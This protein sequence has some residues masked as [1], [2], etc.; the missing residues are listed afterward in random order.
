MGEGKLRWSKVSYFG[1]VALFLPGGAIG[2][3]RRVWHLG[4]N[5]MFKEGRPA[6]RLSTLK[7]D[8]IE[9]QDAVDAF[10]PYLDGECCRVGFSHTT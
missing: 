2:P 4:Y 8:Q 6:H 7:L 3:T 1:S 10:T 5:F 9:E